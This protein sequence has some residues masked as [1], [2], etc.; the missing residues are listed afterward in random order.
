MWNPF[1]LEGKK[2]LVTGASS[3]IGKAAAIECSK[4]GAEIIACGRNKKRLEETMSLLE[5]KNHETFIGDLTDDDVVKNLVKTVD[6]IDGAVLAAGKAFVKPFLFSEKNSFH[7]FFDNNFFSHAE[8]IRQL[9]K[10]KIIKANGSV[11]VIVAVGG[12]KIFV[13]GS[14]VYGTAKAALDSLVRF[15]AIELANKKIRINGISPG[16]TE[17]PLIHDES[18]TD[19]QMQMNMSQYP[20][21]RYG[22]PED[23][24]KGTVF[25]LSDAASWITGHTLVIDGGISA[26]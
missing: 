1:S 16:M 7:D 24:A 21:K 2:I 19:E 4:M 6:A 17:T 15:S 14:S 12:T 5:G 3:G 9:S 25:L 10:N 20:L 11:V 23:I 26:K 13:P 8:L 18:I 22:R